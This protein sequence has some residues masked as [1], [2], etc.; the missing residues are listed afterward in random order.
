MR[1][2]VIFRVSIINF[3]VG[4]PSAGIIAHCL[5]YLDQVKAVLMLGMCGGI[6]DELE[7][8]DLLI[9]TASVSPINA[10]TAM[11]KSLISAKLPQSC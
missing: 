10:A 4:L 8:G 1:G 2:N 11:P 6:D 5:S 9:P 7:I 3:G